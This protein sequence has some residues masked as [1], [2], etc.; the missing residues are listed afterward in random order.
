[1]TER[2]IENERQLPIDEWAEIF[3]KR[4]DVKRIMEGLVE[5]DKNKPK[6]K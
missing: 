3:M 1:M 5:H 2:Y 4:P 6:E